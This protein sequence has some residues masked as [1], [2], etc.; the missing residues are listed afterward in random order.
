MSPTE[1]HLD[2]LKN[3]VKEGMKKREAIIKEFADLRQQLELAD[4]AVDTWQRAYHQAM[5]EAGKTSRPVTQM[6]IK[7]EAAPKTQSNQKPPSMPDVA[8]EILREKGPLETRAL[9]NLI[10]ERQG[11]ESTINTIFVGLNRL[12]GKRFERVDGKWD[13]A[14]R[15][16]N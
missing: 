9:T 16:F 15:C 12:K 1:S 4:K 3:K 11:K 5:I 2:W 13:L 10:N 14:E 8:E 7:I 6:E